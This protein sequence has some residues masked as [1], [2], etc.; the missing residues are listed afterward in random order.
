MNLVK[1]RKLRWF[2][3]IPMSSGLARTILQGT[4]QGKRRKGTQKKKLEDDMKEWAGLDFAG[5][6]SAAKD[7]TIFRGLL[8]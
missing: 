3:N 1:K 2:G 5:S 8:V 4:V 6:T 7:R